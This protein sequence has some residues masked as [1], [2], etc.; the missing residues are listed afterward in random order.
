MG[1]PLIAVFLGHIANHL[2]AATLVEVNVKVGH[3]NTLGIQE[4]LKNETVFERVK[5]R[6]AHGKSRHRSGARPAAGAHSNAVVFGPVNKISHHQEV[7]GKPHLD[8]HTDFVISLCCDPLRNTVGISD[9]K[10]TVHFFLK[11][12]CLRLALWHG[13]A[14]HV[15]GALIKTHRCPLGDQQRVV[16]GLGEL[17]EELAHL[18]GCFEIELVRIKF[19]ALGIIQGRTGLHAQQCGVSVSISGSCVVQII[20]GHQGQ[21]QVFGQL[22]QIPNDPLLEAKPVVH[23]L[24]EV[25]IRSENVTELGCC[26]H[27][28]VVLAKA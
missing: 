22:Q 3:R 18:R 23:D 1:N 11:E 5:L 12:T 19:E 2:T 15:V 26:P 27:S 28:V 4:S 24:D 6:N 16:A 7:A 9:S 14:G 25:V 17:C 21:S 8:N 20:G 13:E 10:T